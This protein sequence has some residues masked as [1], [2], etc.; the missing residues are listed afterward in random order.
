MTLY[1]KFIQ[2]ISEDWWKENKVLLEIIFSYALILIIVI[3]ITIIGIIDK[4][5]WKDF[6]IVMIG[7]PIPWLFA[8]ILHNK[9]SSSSEQG[10][11]IYGETQ[12]LK[13]YS[14]IK[15]TAKSECNLIWCANYDELSDLQIRQYYEDEFKKLKKN[16]IKIKRL[17]NPQNFSNV[18]YLDIHNEIHFRNSNKINSKSIFRKC[19]D[20]VNIKV[21]KIQE[22]LSIVPKIGDLKREIKSKYGDPKKYTCVLCNI[23]DYELAYGEYHPG[24]L[25]QDRE[26]QAIFVLLDSGF[27]PKVGFYFNSIYGDKHK[28]AI[29]CI[30]ALF[31]TEWKN[32]E[33]KLQKNPE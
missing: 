2:L 1:H 5:R 19:E 26:Y 20:F 29:D 11:I 17:I 18:S 25:H 23:T 22:N 21:L 4:T 16:D 32:F 12:L 24:G 14:E 27:H 13:K 7:V 28:K 3:I 9:T 8:E 10:F 31:D 15:D 33:S 30:K 6:F